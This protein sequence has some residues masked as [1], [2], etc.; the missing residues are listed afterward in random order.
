MII[1]CTNN[2]LNDTAEKNSQYIINIVLF[3]IKNVTV[4]QKK[5]RKKAEIKIVEECISVNP[6]TTIH[7][8]GNCLIIK[9]TDT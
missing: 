7:D 4:M 3:V 8:N 6:F 5:Q 1:H 2:H 9:H